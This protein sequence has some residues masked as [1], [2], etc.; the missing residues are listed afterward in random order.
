MKVFIFPHYKLFLLLVLV[1]I[2]QETMVETCRTYFFY[3]SFA[4]PKAIKIEF[5][6]AQVSH[7]FWLQENSHK[8]GTA[9][10]ISMK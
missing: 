10:P 7:R 9:H 5:D 4:I 3:Y 6:Y 2:S 8:I 1:T